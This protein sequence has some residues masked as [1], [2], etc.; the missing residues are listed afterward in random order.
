MSKLVQFVRDMPSDLK[1]VKTITWWWTCFQCHTPV[2]VDA[3]TF[4]LLERR[5]LLGVKCDRCLNP[6]SKPSVVA[7]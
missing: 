2:K 6:P 1:A 7:A 5:K 4:Q 3:G